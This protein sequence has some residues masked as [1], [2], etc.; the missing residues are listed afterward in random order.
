MFDG[1]SDL[2]L[3]DVHIVPLDDVR[4]RQTGKDL[5]RMNVYITISITAIV[6]TNSGYK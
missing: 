1:V 3:G 5:V 2:A 6:I 4:T